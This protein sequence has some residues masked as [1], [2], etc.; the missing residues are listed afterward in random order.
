MFSFLFVFINY[1][2]MD[3]DCLFIDEKKVNI[4]KNIIL[5]EILIS[6][7]DHSYC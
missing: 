3:L 5:F 7:P 2:W 6:S 4:H 1:I